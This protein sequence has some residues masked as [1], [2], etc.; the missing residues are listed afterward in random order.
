MKLTYKA[1]LIISVALVIIANI[2]T[3]IFDFWIYRSAGF[4][5]CGLLWIIH[6]VLPKG[7]EVSKRTLLWARLAGVIPYTYRRVYKGALLALQI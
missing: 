7:A 3:E 6:P 1:Q 2:L 5:L 4:V